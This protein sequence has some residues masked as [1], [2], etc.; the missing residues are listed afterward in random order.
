MSNP[1]GSNPHSWSRLRSDPVMARAIPF[2]LFIAFLMA[3]SALSP[4]TAQA[5]IPGSWLVLT[6]GIIV[7]LVLAWFWPSYDELRNPPP[8]HLGHWLM[9][10]C[11]GL[12]VFA[13]W[14]GWG[15][16]G[17]VITHS[18][19]FS[20]LLPDGG[21]DWP[22]AFL[23][24]AGLALVVPVMEELFWR[25]LV[26]RWIDRH[27]FLSLPPRQVGV[28]AFL[29]TTALF[30]VE[31]DMWV[32]GAIAGMVYN[33]LYI[34]SGNL[35]IPILSHAVTNGVLGVWVMATYNWHYW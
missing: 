19:R 28:G 10:V 5:G 17:A 25:S 9:A 4:W 22:K 7:A 6:R 33:G 16:S 14:I 34:W 27:D 11:A 24:V 18:E 32:A 30:A 3:G 13:I 15:Q 20:P 12:V 29:I 26:L 8:A 23:R 2:L 1:Q 31:H 35:W 21:M